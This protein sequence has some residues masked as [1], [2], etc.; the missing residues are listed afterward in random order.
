MSNKFLIQILPSL[1]EG[2]TLCIEGFDDTPRSFLRITDIFEDGF[3]GMVK[4]GHDPYE[5]YGELYEDDYD[6]I[7]G[8]VLTK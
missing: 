1:K 7:H 8:I 6:L 2:D 5:E 4:F 3:G